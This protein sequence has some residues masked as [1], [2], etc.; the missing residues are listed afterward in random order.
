MIIIIA[1]IVTLFLISLLVGGKRLEDNKGEPPEHTIVVPNLEDL[2]RDEKRGGKR[3]EDNKGEP[4]EHTI[5][6]PNL[7]DLLRDEECL[8]LWLPI[9]ILLVTVEVCEFLSCYAHLTGPFKC[10]VASVGTYVYFGQDA[11]N[12]IGLMTRDGAFI[13]PESYLRAVKMA[14]TALRPKVAISV[15]YCSG[16]DKLKTKLGDVV[17][18]VELTT[19]SHKI[20][21]DG[22]EQFTGTRRLV[23]RRFLQLI[24]QVGDGWKAPLKSPEVREVKVHSDGEILN[25]PEKV[26]TDERRD[27]LVQLYPK[28]LAVEMESEGAVDA[29]RKIPKVMA[30]GSLGYSGQKKLL[31]SA[32]HFF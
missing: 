8:D 16:L 12:K 20:V 13:D 23:S 25:G 29:Y 24:S 5:A 21:L 11:K 7:D 32:S 6:V 28:A 18:P 15:G 4:P 27:Q 3:L 1:I 14:I 31:L 9:D 22:E 2:P 26:R 17:I 30:P 19:Y 10:Y